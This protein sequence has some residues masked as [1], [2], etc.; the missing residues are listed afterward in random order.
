MKHSSDS[1]NPCAIIQLFY[2][3]SVT[4]GGTLVKNHWAIAMV[5]L[6]KGH[7]HDFASIKNFRRLS[8]RFGTVISEV[9]TFELSKTL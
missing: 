2:T 7:H 3:I 1:R 8:E 6:K 5:S 4:S 9:K